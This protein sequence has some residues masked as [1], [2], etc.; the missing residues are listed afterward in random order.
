VN[1]HTFNSIYTLNPSYQHGGYN[2]FIVKS[3]SDAELCFCAAEIIGTYIG[4]RTYFILFL[5]HRM[6]SHFFLKQTVHTFFY[7]ENLMNTKHVEAPIPLSN[8]SDGG[9]VIWWII[10]IGFIVVVVIIVLVIFGA[11]GGYYYHKKTIHSYK[12]L[13][14]DTQFGD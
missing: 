9:D 8:D 12:V 5:H 2:T 4:N 6:I 1:T 7:I 11:I 14:F 13:D 3:T 10:G